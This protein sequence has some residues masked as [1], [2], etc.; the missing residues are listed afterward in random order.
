MKNDD[1]IQTRKEYVLQKQQKDL[2]IPI[3][4]SVR[5]QHKLLSISHFLLTLVCS[6]NF[7][8]YYFK[9]G[10]L[11]R[12]R[13]NKAKMKSEMASPTNTHAPAGLGGGLHRG[14]PGGGHTNLSTDASD[15]G[16]SSSGSFR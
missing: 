3:K 14:G 1:F 12:S 10:S 7:F 5:S 9:H 11:C 15:I 4:R 13:A 2:K 6:S 8:I 16:M